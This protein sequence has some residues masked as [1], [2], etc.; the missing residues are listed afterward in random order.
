M[1]DFERPLRSLEVHAAPT[2]ELKSAL[3]NQQI[4]MDRARRQIVVLALF[5]AALKVA[6]DAYRAGLFG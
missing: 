2:A 3:I 6:Y 5:V 1:P 4:G